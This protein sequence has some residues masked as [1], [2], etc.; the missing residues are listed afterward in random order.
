MA[1]RLNNLHVYDTHEELSGC[2]GEPVIG[3]KSLSTAN[4]MMV[5]SPRIFVRDTDA[6]EFRL[7]PGASHYRR[8]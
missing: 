1:T 4:M 8:P 3:E 7:L 5:P 6:Q 2:P